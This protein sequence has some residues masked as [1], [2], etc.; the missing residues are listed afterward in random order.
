MKDDDRRREGGCPF[1][2]PKFQA[3]WQEPDFAV[4]RILPPPAGICAGRH[5]AY[6]RRARFRAFI[7]LV[8]KI[9]NTRTID[10]IVITLLLTLLLFAMLLADLFGVP[11]WGIHP[12]GDSG[13][14]FLFQPVYLWREIDRAFGVFRDSAHIDLEM[15]FGV[16]C[17]EK[18]LR[19]FPKDSF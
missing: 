2:V 11:I 18:C 12:M 6:H 15:E 1:A 8:H 13:T 19:R 16:K 3:S 10:L 7:R 4:N 14:P 5:K 9:T 17:I